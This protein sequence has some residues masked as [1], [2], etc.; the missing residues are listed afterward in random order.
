M[1][2]LTRSGLQSLQLRE[3]AVRGP[4]LMHPEFPIEQMLRSKD[5]TVQGQLSQEIWRQRLVRGGDTLYVPVSYGL[6]VFARNEDALQSAVAALCVRFGGAL[7][8]ELPSV[9]YACGAQ[10]LEPYM[11]VKLS[12]PDSHLALVRNGVGRRRG[13]TTAV[14]RH[15]GHFVLSA[16]APM[17][18]LLGYADEL[19]EL[20]MGSVALRM[21]LKRYVRIDDDGPEAA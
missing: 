7:I 21:E 20:T 9:R 8:V 6:R 16:E 14:Y 4:T 15:N 17:A 5:E 12:G 18:S 19:D 11:E 13:R 10:V 3:G 2:N 1:M